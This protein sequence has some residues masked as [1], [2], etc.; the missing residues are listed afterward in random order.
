MT[1][2]PAVEMSPPRSQRW[3]ILALISLLLLIDPG[4]GEAASGQRGFQEN[5]NVHD[6]GTHLTQNRPK[7]SRSKKRKRSNK[8]NKSEAKRGETKR[9]ERRAS[10]ADAVDTI[11]SE[12][13]TSAASKRK[14]SGGREY[15]AGEF[16]F[17]WNFDRY[18]VSVMKPAKDTVRVSGYFGSQTQQGTSFRASDTTFA[19]NTDYRV[20]V[21]SFYLVPT[22]L[23]GME[24][25]SSEFTIPDRTGGSEDT[26]ITSDEDATVIVP[27]VT[28]AFPVTEMID[29]GL[30]LNYT[31]GTRTA[32]EQKIS[33]SYP[34]F[35]LAG[36]VHSASY[37][38]GFWFRP[39]TKHQMK[40][41]SSDDTSEGVFPSLLRVMGRFKVSTDAFGGLQYQNE[42]EEDADRTIIDVEAGYLL[43]SL[44]VGAAVGTVTEEIGE[45]K[46]NG[47]RLQASA[48]MGAVTRQNFGVTG[49][50]TTLSGEGDSSTTLLEFLGTANFSF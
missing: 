13:Q 40:S 38:A 26:Q 24:S 19:L 27:G 11:D 35:Y 10:D 39:L 43:S 1:H 47:F 46:E 50:F 32:G 21:G 44:Q 31:I 6:S 30:G 25:S 4:S 18:P 29:L 34:F 48:V 36:G 20:P 28:L 41:S 12:S 3:I 37:E 42:S 8:R 33:S 23:Y 9:S 5:L 14:D 49:V 45:S 17:L 2:L 15:V 16:P 7:K 22:F